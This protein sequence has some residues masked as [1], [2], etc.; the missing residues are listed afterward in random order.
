MRKRQGLIALTAIASLGWPAGAAAQVEQHEGSVYARASDAEVVLGNHLAERRWDRAS[1][2]TTALVDKRAGGRHWSSGRRDFTLT[3]NGAEIG[4]ESFTVSAVRIERLARGGL[5]VVMSLAGPAGL[6]GTRTAEAYPEVAGFRTQTTLTSI[7]PIALGAATLD[8]AAV[9]SVA[10]TSHAFRAGADWREPTWTGPGVFVGD[11]HAGDF[12][13]TRSAARGQALEAPAQWLSAAS[14]GRSLFMVAE[15]ND[16]PSSRALYEDGVARLRVDYTRD[17]LDLGPFESDAHIESPGSGAGRQRLVA[18]GAQRALEPEFTG[19]GAGDGDAEWQFHRYLVDH[20]LLPYSH[21]VVFNSNGTDDNRISTGAKD[22]M[23][24][25]T[26]AQVAPIAKRLGIETFVLDD[27][28]QAISGDWQPDSPQYPEPRWDGSPSSKF[29]PRFPDSTFAAVHRAIAPMQ[30]GLWMSPMHFNPS[31]QTFRA[32]PDWGCSPVGHGL[33]VY[34]AIDAEGGSKEAGIAAWGPAAIPHIESRIRDAL[35]RWGVRY[36]KFDFMAWLDCAGQGDFYDMH[37]AFLAMIDRL[38][39][40]HPGVTFQIDETNDYRLFPFESVARGP[41]WF[42]NGTPGPERLLH[43]LWTLSPYVPAFA[44]GQHFLGGQAYKQ[45]PVD[46]L[47]AAALPSHITFFSDLRSLPAAVVNDAARWLRFYRHN[48]H[49]FDGVV[50]PLLDDPLRRG[51]TALQAWDPGAGRGALL[52]FRQESASATR[53]IALRNVPAHRSFDLLEAPGGT[54][55]G[56]VTSAQLTRGLHVGIRAKRGAH[57]LLVV[58]A[59]ARAR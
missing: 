43:N 54:Y 47:M 8:E 45:Y 3:V 42:Q 59:R 27:G 58:P 11:P 52:A 53:N 32:H 21:A 20:R 31:S 50:Y 46:T 44:I 7:V 26:I 6:G 30:L 51:W 10:A 35:D 2:R 23:N 24:Y 36:F 38:R 25:K 37:D 4:S 49:L 5:R 57:V 22:D 12:R 19:F 48:R 33:A 29:V 18:P 41:T 13:E 39:R 17:V 34:N 56:T 55:V 14:A 15:R 1:L 9:G 28:W 16:F 40:D